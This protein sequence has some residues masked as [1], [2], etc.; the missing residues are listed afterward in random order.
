MLGVTER[1]VTNWMKQG[2]PYEEAGRRGSGHE[3]RIS[4]KDLLAWHVSRERE[5]A[6]VIDQR[7]ATDQVRRRKIEAQAGLA[8]LD[9]LKQTNQ[10]V[11]IDV[12]AAEVGDQLGRV[13]TRLLALPHKTATLV[14]PEE[15]V[16]ACQQILQQQ[17]DEAL[18]ELSGYAAERAAEEGAAPGAEPAGGAAVETAAAPDGER[19]G[20]PRAP[21][22]RRGKRRTRPV[23]D[24][25]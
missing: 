5:Q 11:A 20:R 22:K 2:L 18:N 25:P 13:R 24:R 17:V 7:S 12:V 15:E 4:V 6:G 16:R 14:A 21:A 19:V 8:E 10:V 9:L 3:I 1:T 23:G